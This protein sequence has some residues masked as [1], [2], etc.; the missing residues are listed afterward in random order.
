MTIETKIDPM[1]TFLSIFPDY[2]PKTSASDPFSV[3][4]LL[5]VDTQ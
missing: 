3:S 2:F 4:L 1:H 5:Q